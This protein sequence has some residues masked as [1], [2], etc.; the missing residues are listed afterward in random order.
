MR[1]ST[2]GELGWNTTVFASPGARMGF[3][4]AESRTFDGSVVLVRYCRA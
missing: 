1:V 2:L 3:E 4:L